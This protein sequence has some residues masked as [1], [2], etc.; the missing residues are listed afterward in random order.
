MYRSIASDDCPT[1]TTFLIRESRKESPE[2]IQ[3]IK[4]KNNIWNK[5]ITSKDFE[6]FN[7]QVYFKWLEIY[8]DPTKDVYQLSPNSIEQKMALIEV[9]NSRYMVDTTGYNNNLTIEIEKLGAFKLRGLQKHLQN[10]DLSSKLTRDN[11]ND[12]AS[13]LFLIL[14]GPPVS[15]LDYFIKNKSAKMKLKI[16]RTVQED[17]LLM[18]LRG[19]INRIPEKR[20]YSR[21]ERGKYII[22]R[23]FQHKLW[24]YLVL[25]Y[26]LPWF[27]R[28][29][30]PDEL[31]QKILLDGLDAHEQELI[32]V[33]KQQDMIDHYE[34]FR[35][36]YRPIAFS[37]GF[38]SYYEKFNGKM[39][40]NQE[41]E[42]KRLIKEFTELGASI[43][44]IS[45]DSNISVD[46]LKA[47]HLQRLIQRY[48]EENGKKPTTE[49]IT[50][51]QEKLLK[52]P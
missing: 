3:A 8:K 47:E 18:G 52:A 35:K 4:F 5:I 19:V 7:D 41:E 22:Q 49:E 21:L 20:A 43:I 25:P 29:R 16:A 40:E 15:L 1:L 17:M 39:D 2:K 37:I 42:R 33:L 31:L 38:Y 26:D 51:M 45:D 6:S 13:D 30:I 24:K 27:D 32:T 14:K 48:E 36:V 9:I 44:E 12:F 28:V 23:F 46:Q 50:E 10:F 34:R 11:V